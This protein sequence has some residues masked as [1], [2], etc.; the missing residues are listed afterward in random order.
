M[1]EIAPGLDL[2]RDVLDQAAAPLGVAEDLREMDA[3]LFR[4]EA[5]GLEIGA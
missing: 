4:P 1:T 2:K 5:M 3:R